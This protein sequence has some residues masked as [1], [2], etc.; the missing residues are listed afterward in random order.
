MAIARA[1]LTL[2]LYFILITEAGKLPVFQFQQAN[3]VVRHP[4]VAC[5]VFADGIGGAGAFVE[6]EVVIDRPLRVAHISVFFQGRYTGG[7]IGI[8][9]VVFLKI[10]LVRLYNYGKPI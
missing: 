5:L 4:D 9:A 3:A 8:S 2:A 1:F 10:M 7:A 6:A